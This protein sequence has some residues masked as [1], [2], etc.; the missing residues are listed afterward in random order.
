MAG[1]RHKSTG[2]LLC[3]PELDI[4]FSI[5]DRSFISFDGQ[6]LVHGV[7]P[8]KVRKGGYRFTAVYYSMQQMWKCLP[9]KEEIQHYR[10]SRTDAEKRSPW[11]T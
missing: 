11:A 1:F 2:G 8:I 10:S 6:R 7:T 4:S 3:V 9:L 5:S